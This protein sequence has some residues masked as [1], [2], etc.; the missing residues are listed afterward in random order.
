MAKHQ[1]NKANSQLGEQHDESRS[2]QARL[3][4]LH[5]LAFRQKNFSR[6]LF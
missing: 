1:R 4:Q 5:L 6:Y 2:A 3:T